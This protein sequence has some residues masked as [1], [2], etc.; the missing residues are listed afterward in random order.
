MNWR[1]AYKGRVWNGDDELGGQWTLS[2][3]E[4]CETTEIKYRLPPEG[5]YKS[6]QERIKELSEAIPG[7]PEKEGFFLPEV[8]RLWH[9]SSACELGWAGSLYETSHLAEFLVEGDEGL[10]T[11]EE[12]LEAGG[13]T[14][15]RPN[16][17]SN[18]NQVIYEM[19]PGR[20]RNAIVDVMIN[21]DP[22]EGES[23][24]CHYSGNSS[25]WY[26]LLRLSDGIMSQDKTL[27]LRNHFPPH[28]KDFMRIGARFIV[29][30]V[31][32]RMKRVNTRF[33]VLNEG[34]GWPSVKPE[35]RARRKSA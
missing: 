10:P 23:I 18:E 15:Q 29:W 35:R 27:F 22:V 19:Y 4:S 13:F 2:T 17:Y 25:R 21:R 28:I 14:R 9:Q 5:D 34:E 32:E 26:N 33:Y 31:E 11:T 8:Q 24:V 3:R 7:L 6:R 20:S 1:D 12:I 30:M 16:R